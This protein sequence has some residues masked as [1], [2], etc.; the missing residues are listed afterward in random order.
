MS[1]IKSCDHVGI[2]VADI[3]IV[4]AFFETLGFEVESGMFMESDFVDPSLASP[5][6]DLYFQHTL[7][8]RGPTVRGTRSSPDC[9]PRGYDA[10]GLPTR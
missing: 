4:T 5:T 10:T 9:G 6:P 7:I 8:L 2:T 3:G 1:P